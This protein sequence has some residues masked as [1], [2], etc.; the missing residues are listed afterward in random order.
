MLSKLRA[1]LARS[2]VSGLFGTAVSSFDPADILNGGI[3][4]ARLPKGLLGEDACRLVGSLLLLASLW[5][6]TTRRAEIAE[7]QR[8]DAAV[9]VDEAHNFLHLPIGLEDVLAEARGYRLSLVLAHQHLDQLPRTMAEAI[10][11]N[12]RNKIFFTLSPN[13]AKR[14]AEHVGPYLAQED[15]AR[16]EL[17]QIACRLVVNGANTTG[18][19]ATTEPAPRS[20][21]GPSRCAPPPALT[22]CHA[23]PASGCTTSGAYE[24][25]TPHPIHSPIHPPIRCPIHPPT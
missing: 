21:A 4:L 11:A 25:R 13:D 23:R 6:A 7:E 9:Y 8:L 24:P 20:P 3:L 2:F 17:F 5:Q 14:C 15:L 18:F 22:D 12:A 16:L 19:T 1:V 10:H